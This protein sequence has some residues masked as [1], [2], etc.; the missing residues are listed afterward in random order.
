M[1]LV[2]HTLACLHRTDDHA[3]QL[4]AQGAVAHSA[5]V[6][7]GM[8]RIALALLKTHGL[9]TDSWPIAVRQLLAW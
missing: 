3:G 7:F 9:Q 4:P 8:E 2:L 5:C 6:G 1:R